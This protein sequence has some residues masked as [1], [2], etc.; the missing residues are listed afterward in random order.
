MKTIKILITSK[1]FKTMCT[2]ETIT[3]IEL[4]SGDSAHWNKLIAGDYGDSI[5][6]GVLELVNSDKTFAKVYAGKEKTFSN[7]KRNIEL[8]FYAK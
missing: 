3:T 4:Q 5:K 8:Y 7:V 6:A 1:C 2:L